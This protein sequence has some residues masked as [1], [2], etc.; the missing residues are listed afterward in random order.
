MPLWGGRPEGAL[1]TLE[2][3]A[4]LWLDPGSVGGLT[5]AAARRLR[6]G[7]LFRKVLQKKFSIFFARGFGEDKGPG[8]GLVGNIQGM[9]RVPVFRD[10]QGQQR[11]A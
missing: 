2:G 5:K 7:K 8:N 6:G 1:V 11:P 4:D 3:A 9:T 10:S